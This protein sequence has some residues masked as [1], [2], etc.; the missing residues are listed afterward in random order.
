MPFC[1][2]LFAQI[3]EVHG[4]VVTRFKGRAREFIC[5]KGHK[6]NPDGSITVKTVV[7]MIRDG[8][9][10]LVKGKPI[11]D[12]TAEQI[13]AFSPEEKKEMET[14][15]KEAKWINRK[16]AIRTFM[17]SY[18]QISAGL[19]KVGLFTD[20]LLEKEFS[21]LSKDTDAKGNAVVKPHHKESLRQFYLAQKDYLVTAVRAED[22]KRLSL[23]ILAFVMIQ[24]TNL[25]KAIYETHD[26]MSVGFGRTEAMLTDAAG[27]EDFSLGFEVVD[28]KVIVSDTAQRQPF[29]KGGFGKRIMENEAAQ[30]LDM[31]KQYGFKIM[32]V[33]VEEV[34]PSDE[35]IKKKMNEIVQREIEGRADL[36]KA[37]F[38]SEKN[39]VMA[40]AQ[41]VTDFF[42]RFG[43]WLMLKGA[44][45][46]IIVTKPE[47]LKAVYE[48]LKGDQLAQVEMMKYGQE[49][50]R[51]IELADKGA[52]Y[53]VQAGN[54]DAV[55]DNAIAEVIALFRG[56]NPLGRKG[57]FGGK[58]N[59][60]DGGDV[61]KK[62]TPVENTSVAPVAPVVAGAPLVEEMVKSE[63]PTLDE[64]VLKRVEEQSK[65]GGKK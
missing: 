41:A 46:G 29:D 14:G 5:W 12:Y 36:A 11:E 16:K 50:Q 45:L 25:I 42:E 3:E 43:Y 49:L 32:S 38:E 4:I 53:E 26:Y 58:Q 61:A 60:L 19:F 59:Q 48:R 35:E 57:M 39:I 22:R 47:E 17:L 54:K 44:S 64:L 55:L 21:W 56:I 52:Y 8:E 18:G 1:L 10:F 63:G 13:L 27:H 23:D 24:V 20:D 28:G 65:K 9:T 15:A 40:R 62:D 37:G 31:E 2:F 34:D 7:E 6:I 30:I 33:S 51:I